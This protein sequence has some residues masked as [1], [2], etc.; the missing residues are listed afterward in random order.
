[1]EATYCRGLNGS[2]SLVRRYGAIYWGDLLEATY[3]GD[4]TGAT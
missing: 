4:L 3:W 2:D 1:M